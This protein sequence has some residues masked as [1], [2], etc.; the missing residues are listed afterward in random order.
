MKISRLAALAISFLCCCFWLSIANA[1]GLSFLQTPNGAVKINNGIWITVFSQKKVLYSKEAVDALIRF[2]NKSGIN[3][4]YLQLYRAGEAYYD[5]ELLDRA[6]FTKMFES[7]GVDTVDYLLQQAQRKNIKVFAWVNLLSL[8]QNKKADILNKYGKSILTHDQHLRVSIRDEDINE[9]DKYYLRDDQIFLEPGDSRVTQY[10]LSV[11]REIVTRYPLLGGVHFDY[12]RYPYPVPFVPGSRFNTHGLTYGYG[13]KSITRFKDTT[14][15]DPLR[16]DSDKDDR[17][18]QWD[19]WKRDQVTALV[20]TLSQHVK[21]IS[22][23]FLVSCAVVPSAERAYSVACQDWPLWLEKGIVDY[24]VLM[25]YSR[26]ARLVEESA[27]QAL[28][29]RGKGKVYIGL[30][31]FMVKD[32]PELALAQY[33]S[34]KGLTPDGIVLFSYDEIPDVM[35]KNIK[36]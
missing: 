30:G 10:L 13:E 33:E 26:D 35:I 2:C 15:L 32:D 18:L 11:V 14:G 23:N 3:E 25:D 4:V 28:A 17:Y 21:D 9:T 29:L 36:K 22:K 20:E 27:R 34:V 5:T 8:A 6:R 12:I 7:S 31:L 16:F 19:N 1:E 24:V